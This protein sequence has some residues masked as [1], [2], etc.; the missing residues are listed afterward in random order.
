MYGSLSRRAEND[1]RLAPVHGTRGRGNVLRTVVVGI[2]F[3]V[4]VGLVSLSP[5]L[6]TPGNASIHSFPH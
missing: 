4:A 1:V 2:G 6:L 3:A 5:L